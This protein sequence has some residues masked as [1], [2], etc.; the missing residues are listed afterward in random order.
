MTDLNYETLNEKI[1]NYYK[2]KISVEFCIDIQEEKEKIISEIL[3]SEDLGKIF[4]LFKIIKLDE[5]TILKYETIDIPKNRKIENI[6]IVSK[7]N[8]VFKLEHYEPSNKISYKEDTFSTY[9]KN[10]RLINRIYIENVF[11]IVRVKILDKNSKT[12]EYYQK[13]YT[14]YKSENKI[15]SLRINNEMYFENEN[16]FTNRLNTTIN[17]V[18]RVYTKI[19]NNLEKMLG[20]EKLKEYKIL[21]KKQ[22]Q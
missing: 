22:E 11:D 5:I 7:D 21:R 15:V 4:G 16:S 20:Y 19:S 17:L 10:K 13:D 9:D 1:E 6:V 2:S 8:G 3:K 14:F 12:K 18:G